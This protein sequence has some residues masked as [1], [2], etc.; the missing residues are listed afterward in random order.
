MAN[1]DKLRYFLKR[2][3]TDLDAAHE[4]LREMEARDTEPIAVVGMSCRFPGGVTTPAALW[5]M[6]FD[7]TDAMA[8]FPTDRGWDLGSIIDD[9][10]S[11]QAGTSYVADG[12]FL[13]KVADFDPGFFGISPREALAMDP[14]Q[15][16]LL[17]TS[18]E[19]FEHA[20]IDPEAVRGSQVGVFAG[21]NGQDYPLLL[22]GNQS[23]LE[24]YLG[25]GGAAAVVSGRVSYT[26]GLEGPAVT[27]DTACSSSLV[28]L[29]LAVQSL[30][31]GESSMAL[32]GGVTLMATPGMF[33]D[34]SRQRG[35]AR[36]GRCKAFAD[37]A[38]GT[39]FSEGVGMI[40]LEK[41]SDARR[42]GHE[43]LA[44]VRGSAVNQDGASNGL[45]APNGPSQQRVILKALDNAGLST[46]DI[47]I[48]EGHGTGTTLGDPIEAQ[49]LLATYGQGR[50]EDRPL[51]LGS[52]KSNIGHSQAAAGVAGIMKMVLALQHGVLPQTLHV[53]QPSTHVDW[54]AGNVSLLTENRPWP[55]TG[56]PR[57]AGVSSFG[58]SGTNAHVILEQ[59]PVEEAPAVSAGSS[60]PVVSLGVVPWVLSGRTESAL[61][62]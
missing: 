32:A 20:G 56:A 5:R 8:P 12:G 21:T 26:M 17:E 62:A 54:T 18:W 35:L 40:L 36:D 57:R 47:D 28:A 49:A 52:L 41:L 1:E 33:I 46:A 50:S 9:T 7:G 59:A 45:T 2:V 37:A 55:E 13:G 24:G 23:G 29:H 39:G 30:R 38:D 48:V 31:N 11:D 4:R 14:Q 53:D 42:N 44:V 58:V 61:R 6:V 25:T 16:L 43:V 51:W 15:R 10:D 22:V 60:A 27:V 3:S 34:F 19:A